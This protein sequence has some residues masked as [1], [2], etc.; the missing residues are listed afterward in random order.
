MKKGLLAGILLT[1][2][3]LSA[4]TIDIVAPEKDYEG[5]NLPFTT[6]KYGL[7]WGKT[8]ELRDP[9]LFVEGSKWYLLYSVAGE[10]GIAIGE[11]D[12]INQ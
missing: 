9:A 1:T 3:A 10:S 4:Q 12:F 5:A 6:S 2:S 11:L 8:R 7:F